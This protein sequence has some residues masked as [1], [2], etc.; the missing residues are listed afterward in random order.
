V[1]SFQTR[2]RISVFVHIKHRTSKIK[3]NFSGVQICIEG[4]GVDTDVDIAKFDRDAEDSDRAYFRLIPFYGFGVD[5][6]EWGRLDDETWMEAS[7]HE[8]KAMYTNERAINHPE[9]LR[10][11][12]V[13]CYWSVDP[14]L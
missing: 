13:D 2:H 1:I 12:R 9:M 4:K 3:I 10:Y 7:V 14:R 5:D 11:L 8:G 6:V